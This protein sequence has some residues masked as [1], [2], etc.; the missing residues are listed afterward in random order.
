MMCAMLL[1]CFSLKTLRVASF[2]YNGVRIVF[3]M[4]LCKKFCQQI[5]KNYQNVYKKYWRRSQFESCISTSFSKSVTL[6][7]IVL[8]RNVS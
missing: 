7:E 1:Q 8:H 6:D 5:M 2:C 3:A 4:H